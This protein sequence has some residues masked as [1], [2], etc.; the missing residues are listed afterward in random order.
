MEE[1]N[2]ITKAFV[3]QQNQLGPYSKP[4]RSDSTLEPA[5]VEPMI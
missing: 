3:T 5:L 1:K 2:A 4:V